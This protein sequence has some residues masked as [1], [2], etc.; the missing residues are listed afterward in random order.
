VAPR[1]NADARKV[2]RAEKNLESQLPTRKL[3]LS[4]AQAWLTEIAH[5]EDIDPPL[6]IHGRLSRCTHAAA[7]PEHHVIVV[8]SK[9]PTQLTLLHELAHFMGSMGHGSRFQELLT[10]LLRRHLSIH[11]ATTFRDAL[12]IMS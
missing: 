6:I 10:D 3:G 2:A 12:H 9:R 8:A 7:V 4:E 11:H 1:P 5:A